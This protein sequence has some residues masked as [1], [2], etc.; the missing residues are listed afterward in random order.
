MQSWPGFEGTLPGYYVTDRIA[1]PGTLGAVDP[2]TGVAPGF[3]GGPVCSRRGGLKLPGCRGVS[4]LRVV[5]D[6][7][8]D[9]LAVMVEFESGYL[10]RIDGCVI[11]SRIMRS[12]GAVVPVMLGG[13]APS[14]LVEELELCNQA[15]TQRTV[16]ATM[17]DGITPNPSCEGIQVGFADL[18]GQGGDDEN[19]R[20]CNAAAITLEELP[21]IHPLA[22]CIDS[23]V[24]SNPDDPA[25]DRFMFRNLTEEF[26]AGS[27]Q[28]FQNELAAVSWNFLQF[29]VVSS[30]N[31]QAFDLDGFNRSGIQGNPAAVDDPEC[32]VAGNVRRNPKDPRLSENLAYQAGRCSLVTPQFCKNVKAF[33]GVAGVTSNKVRAAGNQRYGRRTFLWHSGGQGVLRYDQRNVLG[34]SMDFAED[35]LKT[36]WGM[37][38]TW[39]EGERF[40]DNGAFDGVSESDTLNLTVSVDRPTF[41]HFLN[42]NRTFF[43]NTQWFVNYIPDHAEGYTTTGPV[44]LLFTFSVSTGYYQDRLLPS[45]TTIHDVRSAS[46]AAMPSLTYRYTESFSVTVGMLYFWGRTEL[47]DMPIR[48]LAPAVNRTG[49]HAYKVGVENGLSQARRR[50]ELY[51]RVRWTF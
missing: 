49:R 42:P 36:N 39:V 1:A 40:A 13:N 10:P 7:G 46:G 23:P 37:E 5:R 22:G 9:P 11:G 15:S 4:S 43:F 21:L 19:L 18:D 51:L 3:D 47:R 2:V 24:Q 30:C 26:L 28:L 6:G 16:P 44:N 14:G 32:F 31:S 27:A 8:G 29:L 48:D 17:S 25:C 12:N 38:F 50:D 35:T 33:Y 20:V 41:I 34:F 45:F